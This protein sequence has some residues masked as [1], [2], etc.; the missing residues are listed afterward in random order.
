MPTGLSQLRADVADQMQGVKLAITQ[1]QERFHREVN[2]KVEGLVEEIHQSQTPPDFSP[3]LA[4]LTNQM[5]H[6]EDSLTEVIKQSPTPPDLV[7]IRRE[8]QS[9]SE[10]LQEVLLSALQQAYTFPELPQMATTLTN[11]QQQMGRLAFLVDQLTRRPSASINGQMRTIQAL[12]RDGAAKAQ[13]ALDILE[14]ECMVWLDKLES[15]LQTTQQGYEETGRYLQTIRIYLSP[16][17]RGSIP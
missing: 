11:V 7:S 12:I 1:E 9:S 15:Q 3:I 10:H 5:S 2:D 13:D 14:Q 6:V 16:D 4:A 8:L 17:G